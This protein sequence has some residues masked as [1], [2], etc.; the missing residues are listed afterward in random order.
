MFNRF[1][2]QAREVVIGAQVCARGRDSRSIGGAHLLEALASPDRPTSEVLASAGLDAAGLDRAMAVCVGPGAAV[3]DD[4]ALRSLGI[5]LDD[6]R[7]AVEARFGD[8]ALERAGR[9]ADR[10][11]HRWPWGRARRRRD[12]GHIP[13]TEGAKRSLELSL[14][15]AIRLG[16]AS[17]DADHV[18]LGVLR[19]D[20]PDVARLLARLD[21][22]APQI[23]SAVEGRRRRSA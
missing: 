13:F 10:R 23:R 1:T 22:S 15:E 12:S 19:A 8:G 2:A 20:D 11:R 4:A 3:D 6:I 21:V 14:R 7:R 5:D 17:I 9:Q 18:L 16:D